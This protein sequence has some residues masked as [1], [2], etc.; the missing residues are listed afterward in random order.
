ML[1]E[2]DKTIFPDSCEVFRLGASQHLIYPIMKNGS[3]NFRHAIN[4]GRKKDWQILTK[5][6]L[7][8][9]SQPLVTFI[10]NP[11]ERFIS[12][13]NT[14]VQHLQRDN[15]SLDFKTILWFVENYL[16]L[17]RHYCPQF[18]WLINLA[19]NTSPDVCVALKSMSDINQYTDVFFDA[20]VDPASDE[21]LRIID[22]FDWNKLELYFYLDQILV[23]MIGN[24]VSYRE[25]IEQ[26]HNTA[27]LKKLLIDKSLELTY[28]LNALPKT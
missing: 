14:Y 6:E 23:N 12:G 17:N 28:L 16:F 11:K 18:F 25:I 9:I 19:K 10:R 27:I 4:S 22:H 2:I 20:D 26:I 1:N 8:N 21:M 5:D 7:L 24:I 13:V 15:P 3:S